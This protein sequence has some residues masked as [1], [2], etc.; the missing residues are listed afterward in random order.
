[1]NTDKRMT[2]TVP[3]VGMNDR[4]E[5]RYLED[6]VRIGADSVFLVAPYDNIVRSKK[7]VRYAMFSEKLL[8]PVPQ[9]RVCDLPSIE[10]VEHWA[11]VYR[12]LAPKYRARGIEPYFWLGHSLGHGGEL[13]TKVQVPF[14]TMVGADGEESKGC[15]CP[16]DEGLKQYLVDVVTTL[17][18]ADIPLILLDDD[19]RVN[20]HMPGVDIGCFCPLHVD[21][22]N[23]EN[24]TN[25]S[26]LELAELVYRGED[27]TRAKFLKTA[28]DSLL[29]LAYAMEQAVH[30]VN[31]D[32][33]LGLATAMIHYSSEGYDVRQLAKVLAG[34]T[35]PYLRVFGAPYHVKNN[36]MLL[37]YT[38]DTAKHLADY[39]SGCDIEII[40]EGD[41][42]PHTRFFT[43]RTTLQTHLLASRCSGMRNMLHYPFCF[44]ASPD[45][46]TIYVETAQKLRPTM[47]LLDTLLP[48]TQ[49]ATGIQPVLTFGN[50]IHIP[51]SRKMTKRERVWPD[52]PLALKMLTQFGIP[53]VPAH[54]ASNQPVLLAGYNGFDCTDEQINTLLDRGAI[55]DATAAGWLLE[56]GF[57]IGLENIKPLDTVPTFEQY[58]GD[59]SCRYRDEQVW[60]LSPGDTPFFNLTPKPCASVAGWFITG[61]DGN[62]TP[63]CVAYSNGRRK[64]FALGFDFFSVRASFQAVSNMA[65][66][67]QIRNVCRWL[68]TEIFLENE[69]F[70]YINAYTR[71]NTY[72]VCLVQTNTDRTGTIRLHLKHKPEGEIT[73]YYRNG[74]CPIPYRLTEDVLG[75]T[76]CMDQSMSP[77]DLLVLTY[78][79]R[80][81]AQ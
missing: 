35:R 21:R 27:D 79:L 57:D 16:L 64:V 38:V 74:R 65:R 59:F 33:R 28:G 73:F 9:Q 54:S 1:M 77:G 36:P 39:L 18:K 51:I 70:L 17:A 31:P 41:T 25:Y 7:T 15:F 4:W 13:S 75:Y 55:I 42:Y 8:P 66:A 43:N 81:S 22:F 3:L 23:R 32:T 68:G 20:Y 71:G 63:S 40:G 30:S 62:R 44:A 45:F 58:C 80:E 78:R 6:C 10:L 56:R 37:G 76:L 60:L 50:L 12:R 61:T 34:P 2:A 26:G 11:E 47:T 67:E 69:E 24:A 72:T 5:D 19:F 14:Q 48:Q 53:T 52:E 29:E 49:K 46:E